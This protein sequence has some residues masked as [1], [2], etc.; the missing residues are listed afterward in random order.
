MG[1]DL[2][3]ERLVALR[4]LEGV[5]QA[6]LAR[7]LNVTPAAISH[8]VNGDRPFPQRWAHAASQA[9]GVPIEFFTVATTPAD[10]GVLTYKKK[11]TAR[12]RDEKRVDRLYSEAARLYRH[13]ST[14]SGYHSSLLP[15][16]TQFNDDPDLVAAEVRRLGG[17]RQHD[18]IPNVIRLCERLGVGVIDVLDPRSN[19]DPR[20]SGVSRPSFYEDRP[21]I[22]LTSD[23]TAAYKRFLVAHELYHL[24]ADRGLEQALTSTRDPREKRAD[25]FAAALLLPRTVAEQRL[26]PS[27]TLH[28]FLR[29]KAD[30][31]VE[32]RGLIHR[33]GELG[34]V[35]RD[36]ERSL[37]IQWSSAG[38]RE[39]EPVQVANEQPLLL[40]QALRKAEGKNY[41][42]RI[43]HT[44][45]VPAPLITHWTNTPDLVADDPSWRAPV[46]ELGGRRSG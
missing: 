12:V 45:G 24:I 21:L 39:S 10:I 25:R 2:R 15:D 26:T 42:A 22:A 37:Y 7:T 19:A 31:G 35:T 18:P 43:S 6:D 1:T 38:W 5:T 8:V 34:I 33:A 4:E 16:P 41:A 20:H 44:L 3:G 27:L 14:K 17:I 32:V 9:Y 23:H 28:G 46:I 11:S 13:A 36:R 29:V 30:Y 40:T